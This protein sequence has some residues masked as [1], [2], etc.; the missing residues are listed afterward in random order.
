MSEEDPVD[1]HLR[2]DIAGCSGMLYRYFMNQT[3][4]DPHLSMDLTQEAIYRGLRARKSYQQGSKLS[5]WMYV[6]GRS[7]AID[8]FRKTRHDP[9]Q[10]DDIDPTYEAPEPNDAYGQ[11]MAMISRLPP[12]LSLWSYS[13]PSGKN[14]VK[15]RETSS[16]L[17]RPS[18]DGSIT[19]AIA[20]V[21]WASS[22]FSALARSHASVTAI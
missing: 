12:I 10:L 18:E 3:S 5:T 16:S 21:A 11:G 2:E 19:L 14:P 7:V 8:H 17:T 6:V 4:Y 20:C 9:N 1:R 13:L 22:N 15:S